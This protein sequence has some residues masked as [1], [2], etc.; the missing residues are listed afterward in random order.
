MIAAIF[1]TDAISFFFNG[2]HYNI[3]KD[4]IRYERVKKS[5]KAKDERGLKRALVNKVTLKG[6]KVDIKGDNVLVNGV[7]LH[8]AF[9]SMMV[10]LIREGFDTKPFANFLTKL[11]TNPRNNVL[12]E[13]PLFVLD[14]AIAITPDGDMVLYKRVRDNFTDIH[15]GK[16]DN[17]VGKH[18]AVE[19]NSVDDNRDH[20]CS[21]GLHVCAFDYLAHFGNG[22]GNKVIAVKVSPRAVVS[23]PHDYNN[24]KMRVFEYTVLAEVSDVG[25][26]L[27]QSPVYRS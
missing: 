15:T 4:D 18:V 10:R 9:T 13:L 6:Y 17:S 26:V 8:N 19:E 22:P 3:G 24:A 16:F 2:K 20:T 5:I 27:G 7:P 12:N 25:D 14:R 11:Y 1:S 21:H 23:V